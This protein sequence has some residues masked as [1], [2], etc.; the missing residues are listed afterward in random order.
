MELRAIEASRD[1]KSF[2]RTHSGRQ[3]ALAARFVRRKFPPLEDQDREAVLSG[4]DRGCQSG[5][6]SANDYQVP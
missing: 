6:A 1:A 5:R 2:E 3:D 4:D